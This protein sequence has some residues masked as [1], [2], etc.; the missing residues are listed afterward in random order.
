MKILAVCGFGVGS[1]MVLKMTLDRVF[2]QLG[3]DAEVENTD[4]T[5]AK[6]SSPDAIFTSKEIAK[7]LEGAT[8]SPVYG[9]TKYMDQEEVKKSVV[10]FLENYK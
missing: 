10:A 9:I 2:K 4:L 5:S 3:I 1:S 7:D 8:K 6:G